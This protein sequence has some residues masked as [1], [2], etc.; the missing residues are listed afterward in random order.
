MNNIEK[1]MQ[2]KIAD[3]LSTGFTL[4]RYTDNRDETFEVHG[5]IVRHDAPANITVK[6][7]AEGYIPKYWMIHDDEIIMNTKHVG[8]VHL[9]KDVIVSDPCY[10]RDV[11]CMTKLSNVKPGTWEVRAAIDTI[12]SWGERCY[13]LELQHK[14]VKMAAN[15]DWVKSFELG[16]D[17][18][19]MSVFDDA[20]YKVKKYSPDMLETDRAAQEAFD[21]QCCS[22]ADNYA[23]IFRVGKKAVG[24]VCSSGC[25]D[26]GYPLYVVEKNG[27]IVAI[28]ISFM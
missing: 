9:G 25:G 17:S 27:E 28:K 26:G 10:T 3:Y 11:W 15:P 13:I 16:V 12:D 22:L 18:A 5:V 24:V 4:K 7:Q 20:Y 6:V 19:K 14:E 1:T 23:G 8:F 21:A 2:S